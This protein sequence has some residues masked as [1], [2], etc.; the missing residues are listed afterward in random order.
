MSSH[1]ALADPSALRSLVIF[2]TYLVSCFTLS[3]YLVLV[4]YRG[5]VVASTP[6]TAR[7][8]SALN[9]EGLFSALAASSLALTWW[10]MIN[11]F[12]SSFNRWRQRQ[13]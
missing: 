11:S 7:L 10:H 4:L 8:Q 9:R 5:P 1:Q 6:T 13:M 2:G 12:T 3:A